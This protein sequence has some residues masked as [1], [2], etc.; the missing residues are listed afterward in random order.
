MWRRLYRRSRACAVRV[1]NR[2]VSSALGL[3]VLRAPAEFK[4]RMKRHRQARAVA[5]RAVAA[6]PNDVGAWMAL[7]NASVGLTRY[8]EAIAC[9]NRALALSPEAP[10]IWRRRRGAIETISRSAAA[11]DLGTLLRLDPHDADA[12]AIRA[13]ALCLSR[14]FIE[15]AEAADRALDMSPNHVAATRV[16]IQSRLHVCDWRRREVDQRRITAG[17][18]AGARVISPMAHRI[19]CDS[20]AESLVAAR[21]WAGRHT[22]ST[23][24]LW[25]G[26]R[27]RH[28]RIRV[29]YISA[30][31]RAHAVSFLLAGCL[32]HH[33]KARFE[34]TAFSL[35][36]GDGSEPRRRI[37]AAVDRFVGAQAMSDHRIAA[38]MRTLEIDIAVDLNG[39]TGA[40]R[41]G[42]LPRRPAPTQ[43]N[44]LGYPGTMGV[45]FV[46]YILAD[47]VVIPEANQ[48]H[49]AEKVA[50]LPHS[51]L[52][53]GV[54]WPTVDHWPSRAEAGLPDTGF[55][56]ACFNNTLK[57]GPEMFAVWMNLLREIEGSVL[58][59]PGKNARAVASLGHAAEAH[60]VSRNR[61][62]FAPHVERAG[63]LAR[64]ALAD[65]FLDTLPYNAHTTASDA[66]WVG[67]PV[68]TCAGQTFPGRVAA[69]LLHA[70]GVPELVT[71]SLT[72]YEA[73]ARTLARDP[74]RLATLKA[75]L[76]RN[77]D[78]A[79]LFDTAGFTRHL[80]SAYTMMWERQQAGLPAESFAVAH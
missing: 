30:D 19:L 18:A 32:E 73:L 59:L 8:E 16:G 20:E 13:G 52:A 68:L 79:P 7:A 42:I 26:E 38:M 71:A 47:R 58:W 40:R 41:T 22:P 11:P 9:Y 63:H 27:Y 37:E 61:I 57:I 74:E 33:D 15:A 21:S 10:V 51:Y 12:W 6:D 64:Q 55:V 39:Y 23:R 53:N 75:K 3:A 69:S 43:V 31:F 65:L 34:T 5:R 56:F 25:R 72:E 70:I 4:R 67:L 62:V 24:P 36:A 14:R 45:P 50:Y 66:L 2:L 35:H 78:I 77:R 29:A 60:G 44:Y 48:A 1:R 28:D 54:H 46:D 76:V 49:Y 17:L 80:E